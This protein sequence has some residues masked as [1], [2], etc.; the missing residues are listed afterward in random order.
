MYVCKQNLHRQNAASLLPV[1]H[2]KQ[3]EKKGDCNKKRCVHN[4]QTTMKSQ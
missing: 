4:T 2:Q 3:C 1:N